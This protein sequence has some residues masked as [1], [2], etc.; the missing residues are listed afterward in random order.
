MCFVLQSTSVSANDC[1]P[2]S[3]SVIDQSVVVLFDVV[4]KRLVVGFVIELVDGL[5]FGP[6]VG[7][8]VGPVVG[9]AIVGNT[10]IDQ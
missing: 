2:Q 9:L 8:V 7:L 6:V 5:V 3:L 10:E 1:D 4:V